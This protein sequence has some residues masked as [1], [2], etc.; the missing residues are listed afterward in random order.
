MVDDLKV[1]KLFEIFLWEFQWRNY[2]E[3]QLIESEAPFLWALMD[4][5]FTQ[6]TAIAFTQN[7]HGLSLSRSL[8]YSPETVLSG[9]PS[10]MHSILIVGRLSFSCH[11]LKTVITVLETFLNVSLY[12]P[13]LFHPLPSSGLQ[14]MLTI[15]FGVT[16]LSN[17]TL[18]THF[19][20]QWTKCLCQNTQ[21][22]NVS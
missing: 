5:F 2:F 13:V 16:S 9:C 4:V 21:G 11:C 1:L 3:K 12:T 17:L 10:F 20:C 7:L 14:L 8:S 19:G 22:I 18:I 6:R 15:H